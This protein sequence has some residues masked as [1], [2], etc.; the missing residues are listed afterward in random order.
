MDNTELE[1]FLKEYL[2]ENMTIEITT[3]DEVA[4]FGY[5]DYKNCQKHTITISLGNEVISEAGFTTN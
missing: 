1:R 3:T 5:G 2:K 4:D